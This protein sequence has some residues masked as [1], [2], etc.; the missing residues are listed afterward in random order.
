[1]GWEYAEADGRAAGIQRLAGYECQASSA[2]FLDQSNIN[3]AYPYS[4][5]PILYEAQPSVTARCLAAA[6]L[7]RPDPFD[8]SREFAG[9][10]V[11]VESPEIFRISLPDAK[12][13][14]VAPGE[15]APRCATLNGVDVQGPGIRYVQ[16][17]TNLDEICGLGLTELSGV[18]TFSEPALFRLKRT[19][20][21]VIHLTTN[22]G[23]SL[24]DEWTGGS[25]RR[26]EA[27]TL[28]HQW[29]EVTADCRHGSLPG[30]LVDVW[31]ERNQRSL[32]EFRANA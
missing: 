13:A 30:E 14:L 32:V 3:L 4:E 8:P 15:T 21:G 10:K 20:E 16:M 2:P 22:K 26:I 23:I 17:S 5:Q 29:L 12:I 19:S 25:I 27:L 6:T 24:R 9:I 11:E 18:A 31:K 7:V 1:V 28:D